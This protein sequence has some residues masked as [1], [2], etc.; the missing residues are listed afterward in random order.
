MRRKS[1]LIAGLAALALLT[2]AATFTPVQAEVYTAV[3][4][5]SPLNEVPTHYQARP[6]QVASWSRLMSRA[7]TNGTITSAKIN[8]L[9]AVQGF[10]PGTGSVITGLHIH[11][12]IA[13]LNGPVRFGTRFSGSVTQTLT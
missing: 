4:N 5:I 2:L 1:G 11:E 8:Y 6:R 7:D 9:G 13:T 12:G 3:V 10:A